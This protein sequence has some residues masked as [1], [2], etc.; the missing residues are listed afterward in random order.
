MEDPNIVKVGLKPRDQAQFLIQHY[1]IFVGSIL[2]L[3]EMDKSTDYSAANL[4][5]I[6]K[7]DF[8]VKFNEQTNFAFVLI[9]L[10]KAYAGKLL[11]KKP[12][13]NEKVYV[14][15]IIR[16]H[17]SKYVDMSYG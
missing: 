14:E 4:R 8:H 2:D 9:E 15:R 12:D 1:N 17:C 5:K 3:C 16:E 10:F 7:T 13:E 6:C 11:P